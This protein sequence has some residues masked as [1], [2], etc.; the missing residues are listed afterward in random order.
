MPNGPNYAQVVS[1]LR[2]QPRRWLVTGGA[3]FIGS[4]LVQRLLELDQRV[5]CVDDFST[6]LRSNLEA[7]RRALGATRFDRDFELLE[8]DLGD[9]AE[10]S[11]AAVRGVDH[12]LHQAALGS[13]PRSIVE[14]TATHKANVRAFYFVLDA[15]REAGLQRLIFA[16]SSSVYGDA[17]ELPKREQHTGRPLSPYAASKQMNETW[18]GSYCAAYGHSH[19]AL[20]YFNVFG[21]R[22]RPDGPYAAVIPR[23]IERMRSG[24]APQVFGDGSQSRDFTPVELVVQA[25]LV[26]ALAELP[27][28]RLHPY[29]VAMGGR[30]ALVELEDALRRALR[31]PG[32][33]HDIPAREHLDPRAGDVRH[34]LADIRR[35]EELL[36]GLP[37]LSVEQALHALCAR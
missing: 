25:N 16:S 14:P 2:L 36:G 8:G 12:V 6:G 18:A 30:I 15:C 1:R 28:G 37:E 32:V 11:R 10:L 5:R 29:N 35:L 13:V 21:P 9:D 33:H 23:W 24:Q 19:V 17:P 4:H 22:Q 3:G 31:R 20:R 27:P 7:I 26:A 34:S